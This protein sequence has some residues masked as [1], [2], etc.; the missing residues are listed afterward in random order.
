MER[1]QCRSA[2]LS[3]QALATEPILSCLSSST[4]KGPEAV[5]YCILTMNVI[6]EE[7]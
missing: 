2:V 4:T 6:I 1:N 7:P 3:Q 5:N